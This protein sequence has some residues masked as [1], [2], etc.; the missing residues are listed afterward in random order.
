MLI[1]DSFQ[2]KFKQ[3]RRPLTLLLLLHLLSDTTT[4]PLTRAYELLSTV[5]GCLIEVQRQT[6]V[7]DALKFCKQKKLTTH[8]LLIWLKI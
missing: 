3:L 1:F 6:S 5:L 7:T 4:N 2:N 8:C